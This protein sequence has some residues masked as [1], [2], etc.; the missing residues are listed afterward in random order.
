MTYEDKTCDQK[1]MYVEDSDLLT[2]SR[3]DNR[4]CRVFFGMAKW[5]QP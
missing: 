3:A 5:I 2:I 1:L 4:S